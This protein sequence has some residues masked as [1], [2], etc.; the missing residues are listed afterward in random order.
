V[1]RASALLRTPVATR[2]VRRAAA[3][4]PS[5]R[6][7]DPLA[8]SVWLRLL[9]ARGLLLRELRPRIPEGLTMAQFDALAQLERRPLGMTSGELT[10][11]LIVTAGNV[12]GIVARLA[13]R[14]L[15]ERRS[16][17]GD[18]RTVELR[19]SSRGRALMRRVIPR[20]RQDVQALLAGVPRADQ[21]RLRNL[22][23][24]LI[25]ALQP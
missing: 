3:T 10:R 19:L 1:S 24:G 12:T 6:P 13:R 11:E 9:K 2:G 16:V 4:S 22:L 18:R 17:P 23:G 7:D 8:L 20:H 15:V 21:E 14:G 5:A 25:Q